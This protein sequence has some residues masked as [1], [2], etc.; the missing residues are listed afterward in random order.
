MNQY[1]MYKV[2]K[3]DNIIKMELK[4][5]NFE[6][7]KE[8]DLIKQSFIV[9]AGSPTAQALFMY[10][11]AES[12]KKHFDDI[13]D[14]FKDLIDTF[15]KNEVRNVF[16]E[17]VNKHN[18][19]MVA[20]AGALGAISAGKN[21]KSNFILT[22]QIP[23]KE[24]LYNQIDHL[25]ID[26]SKIK[27][28]LLKVWNLETEDRNKNIMFIASYLGMYNTRNWYTR[29]SDSERGTWIKTGQ[30]ILDGE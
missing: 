4:N 2:L 22:E 13:E 17:M 9:G 21:R 5:N 10:G 30:Q 19:N 24:F 12:Q 8:I 6:R 3:K 16:G 26:I 15:D 27:Y 1:T 18:G 28:G 29:M 23:R 11:L 14:E 25:G 7:E 20:E